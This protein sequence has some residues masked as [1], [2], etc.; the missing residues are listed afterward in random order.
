MT[1]TRDQA[2][3]LFS[4]INTDT[5]IDL[6]EFL[7]KLFE[8]KGFLNS[9]SSVSFITFLTDNIVIKG[10]FNK[11]EEECETSDEDN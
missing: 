6:H 9:S 5:F 2:H 3:E 10:F 1:F 8:D 4:D 7:K 11:D